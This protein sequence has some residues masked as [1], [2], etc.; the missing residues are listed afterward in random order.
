[1]P[2][3]GTRIGGKKAADMPSAWAGYAKVRA[4]SAGTA[5]ATSV[6]I[7]EA[8]TTGAARRATGMA[9]WLGTKAVAVAKRVRKAT[10]ENFI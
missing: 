7:L 3:I 5:L 8:S 4:V 1:M 10:A 6:S 2:T 9:R